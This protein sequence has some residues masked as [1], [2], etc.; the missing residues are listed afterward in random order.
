M[1]YVGRVC[2]CMKKREET[3]TRSL[4]NSAQTLRAPAPA[5]SLHVPVMF[6]G[7]FLTCT[8]VLRASGPFPRWSREPR[9]PGPRPAHLSLR[10]SEHK[11]ARLEDPLT[12]PWGGQRLPEHLSPD[13]CSWDQPKTPELG[14]FP[15]SHGSQEGR[16]QGRPHP[17]PPPQR[18]VWA[19][20]G[21]GLGL[22]LLGPRRHRSCTEMPKT[23]NSG[24]K[25]SG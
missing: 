6:T 17:P 5:E 7:S 19:Q 15:S 22:S 8:H 25:S 24:R 11:E 13:P 16:G 1:W 3:H 10:E 14:G 2:V 21:A 23:L 20:P 12:P 4:P 18:Q 9:C